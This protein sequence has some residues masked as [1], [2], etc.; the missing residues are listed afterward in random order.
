[1]TDFT[2]ETYIGVDISKTQLDVFILSSL[3]YHQFT[4]DAKGIKKFILHINKCCPKPYVVLEATGGYERNLAHQLA[5]CGCKGSIVNPRQVRDFAKASGYLAKTDRIDA[6]VIA[7]FA[8]KIPTRMNIN[9]HEA[10]EEI[11]DLNTRR[12]QIVDMITME[13]NHCEQAR[14]S[15]KK[16]IAKVIKALQKELAS[17]EKALEAMIAKDPEASK[18]CQLMCSMKGIGKIT[19]MA[20]LSTLPELGTVTSK[21]VAALTGVAP[22]NCDSGKHQGK[23]RIWGGRAAVRCALFMPAMVAVRRNPQLKE[24][25]D[26]LLAAG[27]SKKTALIACMRKLICILN[28]MIKNDQPWRFNKITCSS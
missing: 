26:R 7:R 14:P 6:Q 27:K 3:Q 18:K 12:R 25:Y 23:R 2:V 10:Q 19:A 28:A 8:E 22:L 1:M 21:E 9:L 15:V 24:F 4:N 5:T 11:A 17:I 16:S 13:K 20:L